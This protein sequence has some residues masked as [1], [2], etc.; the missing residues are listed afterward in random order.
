LPASIFSLVPAGLSVDRLLPGPERIIL[1]ARPHQDTVPCPSC[2]CP[3]AR[4][5]SAYQRRLADLPW[6]G[7]RVELRVQVRRLRCAN[8]ACPQAIFTE[9]LP[10]VTRPKARRTARL[11]EAQT[12]IGLALGGEPGSRLA[13]TLAMPVSGDTLLRLVRAAGAE[14]ITPPRV[15]GV[16]DWAWRRGQ[17]YGTILCDLEENRVIDLLPDR[18]A[19]ALADW[20]EH[21]PGVEVIA[22][23]RAGA[24]ADGARHGAPEAT[25]VADRWHLLTNMSEALRHVADRCHARLQAAAK[26]APVARKAD[27]DLVPA[28]LPRL[29]LTRLEQGQRDRLAARQA[30]FDRVVALR[31]RGLTLDGI[32]ATTGL[33]CST[34]KRWLRRASVPTW[35]KPRRACILDPHRDY[36]ERRWREGCRNARALWRELRRQGF[37]GRP[38]VVSQWAARRRRQENVAGGRPAPPRLPSGRHLAR[39]LTTEPEGL[40]PEERRLVA[41]VRARTPELAEAAE[42]AGAFAR[43][44][45]DKDGSRLDAWLETAARSE[46]AP[47]ARGLRQD[48]PAV[49]AALGLPWSTSPVEGQINRLKTLKR[50][51]YGRAGFDLLRQRVLAAA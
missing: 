24:Y 7:R 39:L 31:G 13:K 26:A 50:Q 46:L 34:V 10:G 18:S 15:L 22:R 32:V 33:S 48:L 37:V 4:R 3:S 17:R 29:P 43:M 51:M 2:A 9:R 40:G 44:V 6:Q 27:A 21:H 42:L 30:R 1:V 47:F 5:H 11:R 16:D 41:L 12:S 45:R 23:D 49:R 25:Q 19:A 38:G 28:A 36:L 14:P 35:R 8:A 20:L